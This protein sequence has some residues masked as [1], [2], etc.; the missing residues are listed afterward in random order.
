MT[1]LEGSASCAA[2]S[3]APQSCKYP[4]LP[5]SRLRVCDA[6]GEKAAR[7]RKRDTR[8]ISPGFFPTVP[9][10]I[11]NIFL[12]VFLIETPLKHT[13]SNGQLLSA[14]AACLPPTSHSPDR[15][16]PI[17]P[18]V[19][20]PAKKRESLGSDKGG[21]VHP[22]VFVAFPFSVSCD[23][24]LSVLDQTVLICELSPMSLLRGRRTVT[25][26]RA[27]VAFRSRRRISRPSALPAAVMSSGYSLL[28][29]SPTD[30]PSRR[31]SSIIP[32]VVATSSRARPLAFIFVGAVC[33]LV[34]LAVS[35]LSSSVAPDFYVR[36]AGTSAARPFRKAGLHAD[37]WNGL[38]KIDHRAFVLRPV[39]Q[40]YVRERSAV[41]KVPWK[42]E[43]LLPLPD[44]SHQGWL[45][46]LLP[47]KRKQDPYHAVGLTRG[48]L[49]LDPVPVH[50]IEAFP[51]KVD[52][53]RGQGGVGQEVSSLE[54]MM[55]GS[56]TTTKRAKEMTQLWT[57]WM[58]PRDADQAQP[59]CLIL[60]SADETREDMADLE[61][62]LKN[63]GLPCVLKQSTHERYEVR[64][65]SMI[66]EMKDYSDSLE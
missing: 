45:A 54:R 64:V 14:V 63:R 4:P 52:L 39:E 35:P 59:A 24:V 51:R 62:V 16:R 11:R 23:R 1:H 32:P 56:V 20:P 21:T 22:R 25:D 50:S 40:A 53:T 61:A 2:R 27:Q 44:R 9:L 46:K 12:P 33:F 37:L 41:D 34:F 17:V 13:S 49:D 30:S 10:S 43:D 57:N 5:V 31:I 7:I 58:L 6:V 42:E 18:T 26:R 19:R 28:P 48:R 3:S 47:A 15:R 36:L 29:R 66:K 55:F 60:L 38:K 8:K 65:M